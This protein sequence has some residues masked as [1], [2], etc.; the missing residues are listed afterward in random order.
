VDQGNFLLHT[1]I[2]VRIV[3][4][5]AL[6]STGCTHAQ[7]KAARTVG[8]VL[9]IGGVLGVLGAIVTARVTGLG[10]EPVT[11]FSAVSGLGIIT[12]ATGELSDPV[13]AQAPETESHK[14][15][16]WAKILTERAAG[17]ARDGRCPRVRRYEKRVQLYDPVIHDLVFMRDPE[18]LRCLAEPQP[19][20][21]PAE[22]PPS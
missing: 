14:L 15:R 22:V 12:Y 19:P 3:L 9:A 13:V 8:E 5:L 17:A 18:I 11:A 16:R 10:T 7:A 2:M 6:V 21:A 4:A 1:S 20:A